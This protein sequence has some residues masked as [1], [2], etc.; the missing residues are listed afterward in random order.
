MRDPH[1][2]DEPV[3]RM[4][5][6]DG[7]AAFVAGNVYHTVHEEVAD[8]RAAALQLEAEL[9]GKRGGRRVP[10]DAGEPHAFALHGDSIEVESFAL[11]IGS[12]RNPRGF[13]LLL[14][15]CDALRDG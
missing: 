10:D 3:C 1:S 8:L 9:A 13:V 14:R 15:G 11:V 7:R 6:A 5:A 4:I 12:A 2:F